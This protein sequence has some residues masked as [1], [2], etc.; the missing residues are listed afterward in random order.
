MSKISLALITLVF[1]SI[2][3]LV[4]AEDEAPKKISITPKT[5]EYGDKEKYE[6][7]TVS[8]SNVKELSPGILIIHNWMGVTEETKKQANRYA[9]L[10]YVV[11]AVDVYGKGLR[12]KDTKEAGEYAT[13]YK[14]DR[15]LFRERLTLGLEELK[16]QKNVDPKKIAVVGYCFGGT[17]AIELARSG[18]DIL[19][20]VSFH[21]G[22]D[23]PTPEDGKNIKAKVLALCGAI[24]PYVPAKDI[25][26]F[27]EEMNKNKI[28]CQIV[29]YSGTVHSFTDEGAGT[30]ITK[31]AAYNKTSDS[32]SYIAAQVF[33]GEVFKAAK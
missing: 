18:A 33:L 29:R 3:Y 7:Y 10:G 21:G 1:C 20:A 13:K 12:P 17:G 24:D 22:L 16:K 27:E 8:T 4:F 19:A 15:K 9:A 26:A 28:D 5:I 2:G 14:S 31:G 23:S 30:D 32:R 25:A 6:G 11:F